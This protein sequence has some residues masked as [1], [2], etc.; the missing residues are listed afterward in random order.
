[1]RRRMK[2]KQYLLIGLVVICVF[3]MLGLGYALLSQDLDIKGTGTITSDWN[4][5]I[6]DIVTKE[7]S[8]TASNVT[9]PNHSGTS[10]TINA[11]FELPG[12][13]ISYDITVAN[14]GTL[15]A[16]LDSIKIKMKDQEV[17]L[18]SVEGIQSGEALNVD[19]EKTFTLTIRYNENITSTPDITNID[20]SMNLD[21]LQEGSESN[22]AGADLPEMGD[23]GIQGI[24]IQTEETSL[25]TTINAT[26]AIKYYFSLDNDKWYEKTDKNYT[27]YDL[28]PNTEYTIYVKAEDVSG[29]VVF[30]SKT[31]KTD[32]K[33]K[34]NI[35]LSLGDH[36]TGENN[37]YQGLTIDSKITDND[38]VKE[39]LYCSTTETNCTPTEE[40]EL[41]EGVGH[42]QFSS[43]SKGQ[44]V[45]I[46]ATDRKGNENTKCSNAYMIDGTEPTL[47]DITLTPND[48]TMTITVN[49]NDKESGLYTYYYI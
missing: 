49:S 15:N 28:K 27:F 45:C 47:T 32:D 43:N 35:Q 20:L 48:D 11:K 39:A 5:L 4:I 33:T 42:V 14:Q 18:F 25:V 44:K 24:D 17:F 7:K 1:M 3:L 6:T 10:A 8:A 12:D 22:F 34:P 13:Y 38:Q 16:V 21:Y 29:E 9:E 36:Q 37:W 46:K 2:K 40:L 30:S 41:T 23:L 26:N 31:V 19:E